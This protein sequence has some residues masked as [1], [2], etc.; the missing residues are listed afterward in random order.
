ML[1]RVKTPSKMNWAV[2]CETTEVQYDQSKDAGKGIQ[3]IQTKNTPPYSQVISQ[4]SHQE[5]EEIHTFWEAHIF[6]WLTQLQAV[7]RTKTNI[8]SDAEIVSKHQHEHIKASVQSHT[9]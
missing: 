9:T 5:M 7:H 6:K 1:I 3:Y 4:T 8:L 2:G